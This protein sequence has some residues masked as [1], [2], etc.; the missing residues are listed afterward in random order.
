M[1]KLASSSSPL[2][3]LPQ[4][5]SSPMPPPVPYT[6]IKTLSY[7]TPKNTIAGQFNKLLTSRP[8]LPQP[9]LRRPPHYLPES[10]TT[11]STVDVNKTLDSP[12]SHK[13]QKERLT[14]PFIC[15]ISPKELR[16]LQPAINAT[17]PPNQSTTMA[18]V[19]V[20][21]ICECGMCG[22]GRLI[23]A[24]RGRR[25]TPAGVWGGSGTR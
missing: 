8:T 5:T 2:L 10:T 22:G 4:F 13:C 25:P 12:K 15:S 21:L 18:A 24:V 7:T 23:W 6:F 19:C 20:G 9:P 14:P 3:L 16:P 11:L 1:L 17:V